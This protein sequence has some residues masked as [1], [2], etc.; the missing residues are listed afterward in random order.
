M[1]RKPC[2]MQPM[3]SFKPQSAIRAVRSMP[4]SAAVS[5]AR[6]CVSMSAIQIIIIGRGAG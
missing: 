5:D 2:S 3:P 4:A 6:A 1:E